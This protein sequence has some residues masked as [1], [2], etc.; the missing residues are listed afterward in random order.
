MEDSS[1]MFGL[2]KQLVIDAELENQKVHS[3]V[4]FH[5]VFSHIKLGSPN[6]NVKKMVTFLEQDVHGGA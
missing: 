5:L 3:W 4:W 1:Q 2:R 6:T